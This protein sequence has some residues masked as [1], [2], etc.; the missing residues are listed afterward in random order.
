MIGA[1][2]AEHLGE[3]SEQLDVCG[4]CAALDLE[5]VTVVGADVIRFLLARQRQGPELLHCPG[6]IQE[7]MAREGKR[8]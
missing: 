3:I 4:P 7:W 6:Y 8:T 5:E 1:A 2:S